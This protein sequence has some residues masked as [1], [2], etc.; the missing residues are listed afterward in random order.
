VGVGLLPD[1][2]GT[3]NLPA[4]M[5]RSRALEV[6]L[7][8]ADVDAELAERYGWINR[9][10]PAS[11]LDGFVRSLATRIAAFPP[12]AV[13]AAKRS[14]DTTG[15]GDTK[16]YARRRTCSRGSGRAESAWLMH[17]FLAAGGQ[18]RDGELDIDPLLPRLVAAAPDGRATA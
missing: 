17:A 8:G 5:G 9:A 11:D 13:Q 3:Q 14:V 18:T 1:G 10:I 12:A 15:S 2:G 4:L 6:I 16:G 7:S